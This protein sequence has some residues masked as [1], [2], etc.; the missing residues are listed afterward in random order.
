MVG[1]PPSCVGMA[2][3]QFVP[4]R[5]LPLAYYTAGATTGV[6]IGL[7]RSAIS[8][9]TMP[10]YAVSLLRLP[11]CYA[12]GALVGLA[13]GIHNEAAD[14][15]LHRHP[16]RRNYQTAT[17][18]MYPVAEQLQMSSL[19]VS[20]AQHKPYPLVAPSLPPAAHPASSTGSNNHKPGV[21]VAMPIS[22]GIAGGAAMDAFTAELLVQRYSRSLPPTSRRQSTGSLDSN[23][24]Q[25]S[26]AGEQHG[27]MRHDDTDRCAISTGGVPFSQPA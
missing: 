23:M 27:L 8:C 9:T 17:H 10:Y 20:A 11:L 26:T 24:G 14:A 7:Q 22:S 15:L 18:N 19:H 21:Y 13:Q 5:V 2:G 4:R 25:I 16:G 12:A 1:L 3:H 6:A